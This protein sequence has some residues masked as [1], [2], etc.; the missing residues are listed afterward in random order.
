MISIV[1]F[2]FGSRSPSVSICLCDTAGA[3]RP[4]TFGFRAGWLLASLQPSPPPL[5]PPTKS[6]EDNSGVCSAVLSRI[7]DGEGRYWA[8]DRRLVGG[9]DS[10][11]RLK[12]PMMATKMLCHRR[13]YVLACGSLVIP[14]Y[15]GN[16]SRGRRLLNNHDEESTNI[17]GI[18]NSVCV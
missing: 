11:I 7:R 3:P 16:D 18:T 17:G 13:S 12:L 5:Q 6:G 8:E 9:C 10:I 14:H 2:C 15:G 4:T 1:T